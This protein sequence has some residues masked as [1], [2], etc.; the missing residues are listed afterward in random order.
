MQ[1]IGIKRGMATPDMTEIENAND[2][3]DVDLLPIIFWRPAKQTKIIANGRRQI[4]SVN[5]VFHSRA[6]IAFTHLR[7]VLVQDQRNMRVA[8]RRRAERAENLDMLRRIRE[9]IFAADHMRDF[10][11]EVVDDVD[12]MENP[13]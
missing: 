1:F 5:V 10:H 7:A 8:R 3:F 2:L 12:E 9:M 4:S 13:R 6:F 11:L